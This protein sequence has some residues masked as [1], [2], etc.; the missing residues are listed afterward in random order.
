MP[1]F[2]QGQILRLFTYQEKLNWEI[3]TKKVQV[4]RVSVDHLT[5][6]IEVTAEASQRHISKFYI[7]S[8]KQQESQ[9]V[10]SQ[11]EGLND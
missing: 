5:L 7:G 6:S 2:L 11:K 8:S 10:K 1:K 9:T 3:Y 4:P